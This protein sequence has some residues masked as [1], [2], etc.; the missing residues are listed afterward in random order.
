MKRQV[1]RNLV[2]LVVSGVLFAAS[3]ASAQGTSI[4]FWYAISGKAGETLQSMIGEFN[5][6]NE[7]GITVNGTFSGSYGDTAQKVLAALAANSLPAGG[8]VPAGPLWTCREGNYLLE[9][10]MAG[11]EG[12]SEDHF[13]PVLLDYNRYEGH[14]CSL[15]FNNSTMVMFYNKDLMAQAGLDP[16][17][18]PQTWDE[19]LD[20]AKAIAKAVPG[21]IGV[22]VRDEAWWLKGL[23]LQNGGAIVTEDPTGP[24]FQEPAG[25]AA[26]EY[27]K[28]LVDQGLMPPAQHDVS[29]DLFV[30]GRVAF[31]MASTATLGT[32]ADGAAFAY[33]T[34]LLPGKVERGSTVG[35]AALVMFPSTPEKELAT[36]RLLKWLTSAENSA[37]FT[38][39]TGYVPTGPE[40]AA[41]ET[42]QSL[43]R[44]QPAY[45]AGFDQLAVSSQYPHFFEMGTMDSLLAD[46]IEFVE[47]GIK[48]PPQ[49]LDDAA[50]E[51]NK[52]IA[53]N[54]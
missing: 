38:E 46:A 23:I 35:G 42:V 11:P 27:W 30:G 2:R 24:A 51:L 47:L 26:L 18:P 33:G 5:A 10:Y 43:I 28:T 40:A 19:L 37:R 8:L 16:A 31:L 25:V 52:E 45:A 14:L 22:E 1:S 49:A 34:D 54:Q 3:L 44:E 53:A 13:F 12:L 50:N 39:A 20:Q 32:V 29:R 15:P 48:T 36:W 21:S 41:S 6:S 4:D 17:A 9:Q 7:F